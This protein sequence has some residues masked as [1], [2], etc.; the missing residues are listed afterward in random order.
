MRHD[1]VAQLLEVLLRD[2]AVSL[3]PDTVLGL[4]LANDELVLRR[5]PRE[6]AGVDDERAALGEPTFAAQ[7]RVGVELR[8]RRM[9]DDVAGRLQAVAGEIDVG[10]G[11]GRGRYGG[12]LLVPGTIARNCG[13]S[14]ARA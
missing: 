6:L 12:A 7:E 13:R 2:L 4:G 11:L 14:T 3:P 1:L 5:A 10:L 9:P 8:R